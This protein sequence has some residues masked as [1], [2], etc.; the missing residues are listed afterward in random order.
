[1]D[2]GK[3]QKEFEKTMDEEMQKSYHNIIRQMITNENEIRNQRTNWFL[4]IQGF[5]VAGGC[6][7]M[8]IKVM[9]KYLFCCLLFLL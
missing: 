9:M 7:C 4:V 1:M 6:E 2:D 8:L 3:E 5:L